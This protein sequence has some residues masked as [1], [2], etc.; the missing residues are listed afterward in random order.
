MQFNRNNLSEESLIKVSKFTRVPE[1]EIYGVA[2][3]YTQFRLTE[4]GKYIILLCEGT[5]CHVNGAKS[6]LS[7]LEDEL[8]ITVGETTEDGVF[9]LQSVACLGC[10]SLAPVIMI[11]SDAHGNL[12]TDK[13]KRLIKKFKSRSLAVAV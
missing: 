6:I 10:C 9:T 5:A 1:S 7:V 3:F 2:T 13:I 12:N 4:M 11:N 8:N